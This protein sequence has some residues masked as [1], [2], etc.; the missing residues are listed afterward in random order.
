MNVTDDWGTITSRRHPASGSW[1]TAQ[2]RRSLPGDL[3]NQ[4]L[5]RSVKSPSLLKPVLT[6]PG[7]RVPEQAEAIMRAHHEISMSVRRI[8]RV[9]ENSYA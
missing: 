6:I 4:N 2:T 7:L 1:P 8:A 3:R 5:V 9:S